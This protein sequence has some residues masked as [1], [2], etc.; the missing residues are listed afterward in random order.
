MTATSLAHWGLNAWQDGGD[1][2]AQAPQKGISS[3]TAIDLLLLYL[4]ATG[5]Q[6]FP[7]LKDIVISRAMAAGADFR[8]LRYAAAGQAPD[9]LDAQTTTVRFAAANA[10]SFLYY[11]SLRP[12][13]GKPGFG[14][15]KTDNCA[16]YNTYKYGLQHLN[17]YAQRAGSDA[18]RLRYPSRH[19]IILAGTKTGSDD[20]F[21][22]TSCAALMQGPNRFMRAENYD[23]YISTIFNEA[24]KT[25]SFAAIADTG[26]DQVAI[27]DSACGMNVLFG[28]GN[29]KV[30]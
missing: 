7:N 30:A 3:F 9:L 11:T 14:L 13:A 20:P 18:I 16:N 17:G 22:D 28:D 5:K 6:M 4:S 1:S 29:C 27:F 8:L 24:A 2:I 15:P 26:Y 12:L 25:Q 10:S 23:L 21:P 19:V